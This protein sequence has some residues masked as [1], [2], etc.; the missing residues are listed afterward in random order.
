M[1]FRLEVQD[2]KRPPIPTHAHVSPATEYRAG[3]DGFNCS[4]ADCTNPGGLNSDPILASSAGADWRRPGPDSSW[5]CA[6]ICEIIEWRGLMS[7]LADGHSCPVGSSTHK[8]AAFSLLSPPR[9]HHLCP[10]PLLSCL[11]CCQYLHT[12][13]YLRHPPVPAPLRALPRASLTLPKHAQLQ[14]TALA[15][16]LVQRASRAL[17]LLPPQGRLFCST[18]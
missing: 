1:G 3:Q 8:Q 16:H 9:R 14:P 7:E 18:T 13:A 5:C 15:R 10:L 4:T 6:L 12:S 17:Q 11:V 2:S